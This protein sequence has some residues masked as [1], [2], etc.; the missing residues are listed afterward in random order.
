[1]KNRRRRSYFSF[2][3][4]IIR[5]KI[6]TMR[7]RFSYRSTHVFHR[8][9]DKYFLAHIFIRLV[10][11]HLHRIF[12]NRIWTLSS[13]NGNWNQ[14]PI[15]DR[16]ISTFDNSQCRLVKH[17]EWHHNSKYRLLVQRKVY[18]ET[19]QCQKEMKKKDDWLS[20]DNF[21]SSIIRWTTGCF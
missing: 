5:R 16:S 19:E 20:R 13:S 18:E 2:L 17:R 1:M 12:L 21:R 9:L 14:Q 4:Y 11:F 10:I 3:R 15:E 7:S 8:I 6:T